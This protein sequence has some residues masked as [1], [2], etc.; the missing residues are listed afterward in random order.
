VKNDMK[1]PD[2]VDPLPTQLEVTGTLIR[3]LTELEKEDIGKSVVD[4]AYQ[5]GSISAVSRT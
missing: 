4:S 5:S 1:K 3:Y 2:P